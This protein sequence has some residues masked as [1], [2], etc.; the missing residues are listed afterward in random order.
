MLSPL[1]GIQVKVVNELAGSKHA[2]LTSDAHPYLLVSPAMYELI[3]GE[4]EEGNLEKILSKIP[5][6]KISLKLSAGLSLLD[7]TT[8][9]LDSH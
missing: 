6:K 2:Y 3:K 5:V 4:A 1:F 8:T 9:P 7:I